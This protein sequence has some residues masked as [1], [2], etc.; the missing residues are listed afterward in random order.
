MERNFELI[1]HV[2]I[3][4]MTSLEGTETSQKR[5]RADDDDESSENGDDKEN[6]ANED[7]APF[8]PTGL[9]A[10]EIFRIL[11]FLSEKLSEDLVPRRMV[12][13]GFNVQCAVMRRA[14]PYDISGSKISTKDYQDLRDSII[15]KENIFY[16]RDSMIQKENIFYLRGW[17]EANK[18]KEE[19]DKIFRELMAKGSTAGWG[20]TSYKHM[21]TANVAKIYRRTKLPNEDIKTAAKEAYEAIGPLFAKVAA[22]NGQDKIRI[23]GNNY[24]VSLLKLQDMAV[25]EPFKAMEGGVKEGEVASDD[26]A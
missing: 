4:A 21:V 23:A 3:Y 11:T 1:L 17:E 10:G 8:N 22:A 14:V 7:N 12:L 16:L 5:A 15:Q 6:G 26:E 13:G 19:A 9:A 2:K 20:Y 25:L 24:L 18:K